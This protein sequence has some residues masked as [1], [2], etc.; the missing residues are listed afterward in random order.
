[1]NKDYDELKDNLFKNDD[2]LLSTVDEEYRDILINNYKEKE[3][4]KKIL[5]EKESEENKKRLVN[6]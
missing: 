4:I 3:R 1:M 2:Q 5:H 6:P